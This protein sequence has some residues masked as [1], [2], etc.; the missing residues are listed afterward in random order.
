MAVQEKCNKVK[1]GLKW[2]EGVIALNPLEG[3]GNF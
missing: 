2:L 3:N 1:E